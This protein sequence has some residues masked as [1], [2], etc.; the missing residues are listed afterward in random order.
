MSIKDRLYD[1]VVRKNENVRYEY[2]RYVMEHTI[3][4]YENRRKHWKILWKLNWHYRIKGNNSPMLYFDQKRSL[5]SEITPKLQSNTNK[6]DP[7]QESKKPDEVAKNTP[8]FNGAESQLV[9]NSVLTDPHHLAKRLKSYD[10]I[11][12]DIF[13]TLLFRTFSSPTDIFILVGE[14]LNIN[15]FKK[16]RIDAE[17]KAREISNCLYGTCEITIDDIYKQIERETG[18]PANKGIE[19]EINLE[20]KYCVANPYMKIVFDILIGQKCK[21]ILTSDMYLGTKHLKKILG[22]C[23]YEG[24]ER[25]FVSC[26][27]GCGKGGNGDLFKTVQ[28]IYGLDKRICHVGDNYNSDILVARKNGWDAIHFPNVHEIGKKYRANYTGMSELWG[29]MY[30]AIVNIKLHN[31]LEKY[32]EAFEYG[33]IYG[34][35]YV[36]GYCNWIYNYVKKNNIDKVLFLSRDGD[37]YKRV[38]NCLFDDIEN[39]YVYWSRYPSIIYCAE[40]NRYDFLNRFIR[41]RLNDVE[42]MQLGTILNIA[43]LDFLIEKLPEYNLRA[44]AVISKDFVIKLE[45][46]IID[47]WEMVLDSY[48]KDKRDIERYLFNVIGD[49]KKIAVVD[50]GWLGSG[51]IA[52]KQL[53]EKNSDCEVKCLCAASYGI[54]ASQ[55]IDLLMKDTIECYIFDEFY[56][57]NHKDYHINNNK[58]CNNVFFEIFTQAA[59]P[60]LEKISY[61]EENINFEYG[62]AEV[63]NYK[64]IQEIHMGIVEFAQDYKKIFGDERWLCSISGYDAYI[65]FRF[66]TQDTS[67]IKRVVGDYVISRNIGYASLKNSMETLNDLLKMRGI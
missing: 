25:L 40:N 50:V 32:S 11:S 52:I 1:Y 51:P 9:I 34:G 56:N 18:I 59:S 37:I 6:D 35:L 49:A 36:F 17:R 66:L 33:Y 39:E 20:T 3:E 65:P 61:L 55:N 54:P 67:L 10:I 43:K 41:H 48:S 44:D 23:G 45:N 2:E 47:N 27:I 29:S 24:Y 12:F 7:N 60:S 8:Y 22:N 4:H 30:G 38:F 53:V 5:V 14:K 64:I 31:N 21:V 62:L 16:I 46:L 26:E 15:N 63:E 28:A 58:G 42:L 13:D 57:R 19:I